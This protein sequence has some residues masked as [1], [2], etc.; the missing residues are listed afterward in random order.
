MQNIKPPKAGDDEDVDIQL[1]DFIKIFKKDD[2][3]ENLITVI[4]EEVVLRKKM[5]QR[6][7]EKAAQRSMLEKIYHE[8]YQVGEVSDEDDEDF[9]ERDV[10]S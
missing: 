10:A 4:N 1:K 3:S 7:A 5:A 6:K 9:E 2:V 8:L